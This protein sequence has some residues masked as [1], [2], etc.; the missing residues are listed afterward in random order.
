M[1]RLLWMGP[2]WLAVALAG[3]DQRSLEFRDIIEVREPFV[4][5]ISPDGTKVAFVIGTASLKD[6]ASR[7]SLWLVREGAPPRMLLDETVI[8]IPEWTAD[9]NALILRLP[10]AG[11]AAFWRLALSGGGPDAVFEHSEPVQ[12]AWWSRDGS[13]VLFTSSPPLNDAERQRPD[14][15]G[16]LYDETAHG[17]RSFTRGTWTKPAKPRLWLWQTGMKT[18]QQVNA[19]LSSAGSVMSAVW[20][21]DSRIVA[22]T[23][24]PLQSKSPDAAHIGLLHLSDGAMRFAELRAGNTAKRG[25][26]WMPDGKS[27]VYAETG[28]PDRY[29]VARSA[30]RKV[31]LA[32]NDVEV[33]A[34]RPWF[35]LS[36]LETDL[37][38]DVLVEYENWSRSALY[39]VPANGG[40]AIPIVPGADH[41][42][43]ITFSR[44]SRN[45]ACIRQT[46][47][48]PPEIA[49]IDVAAGKV[50]TLTKLNPQLD[51]IKLHGAQER[52][53]KNRFGHETNGFLML[54]SEGRGPF[55][56]VM[57][58]YAVSSKFTTQSQ[59]MTSYPAQHLVSAGIAV[60][61][62]NNHIPIGWKRGDFEG[63]ALSQAYSP[64]AS[65]EAAVQSLVKEGIADPK[66]LGIAGWSFGAWLAELAITQSDMFRVASAGEGGLNNAGQYWVVGSAGMQDYLDAFFGGPPFGDAYPNYKRI[67][68]A[69]NAHRVTAPLLREYGSDVGVQS[70]EF[71][72]A[73]RRLGK[74]VEQYIYPKAPHI[75]DLP[76]HRVASMQRNLDWFRF[77]LQDYEDPDPV[78][79]EQ[80]QRWRKLRETGR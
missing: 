15:E 64:L 65:M 59:W 35:Y 20:S 42:S 40:P 71:Y 63:A 25:L 60:L 45:A 19:D 70:L 74:P 33:A 57:I 24:A 72:M 47:S 30:I 52:K 9:S 77:W 28:D 18:P 29:S 78:R 12:S 21:P 62:H 26:R 80:Y 1:R 17:I 39:R 66:R 3:A 67:A 41:L 55:P 49:I 48:S 53:W 38:G 27:L 22:I 75:L 73:L 6:N 61:L 51:A 5:R 58:Q 43:A 44:D 56:L 69:L 31:D 4:P 54:P 8:G 2:F 76:S 46:F 50:R 36:Q 16:I 68:P 37:S 10:R 34:N 11:K 14:R 7:K 13:S 79:R 32:G 23:Y